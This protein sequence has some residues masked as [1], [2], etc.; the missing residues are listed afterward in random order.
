[1]ETITIITNGNE[2][3]F[4][5]FSEENREGFVHRTALFINGENVAEHSHQYVNRTW[6]AYKFKT[7]MEELISKLIEEC[8]ESDSR[9][10]EYKFVLRRLKEKYCLMI[11]G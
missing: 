3:S 11:G 6:E 9:L 1:M 7:V 8:E 10:D 5:N 4:F 2:Y